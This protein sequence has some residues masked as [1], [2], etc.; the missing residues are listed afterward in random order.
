[1][2]VGST[3]S[4]SGPQRVRKSDGKPQRVEGSGFAEFLGGPEAAD[5]PQAVEGA[6]S[7]SGVEA[8]LA[9]QSVDPDGG[10]ATRRRMAQRGEDVLDRLEGVRVGLLAGR[11]P[12]QDL[13]DLARLVRAKREAGI[14]PRLGALL[15]EIELRAEVELAKLTRDLGAEV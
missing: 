8:I 11:V 15:D 3:G 14:D 12:K 6:V 4:T 5:G 10:Q 1:M 2:K 13:A 9:A 7:L